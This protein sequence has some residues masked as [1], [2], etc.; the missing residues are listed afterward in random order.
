MPRLV[1]LIYNTFTAT[2][3]LLRWVLYHR[4]LPFHPRPATRTHPYR[5]PSGTVVRYG[6][7]VPFPTA[8]FHAFVYCCGAGFR[9]AAVDYVV[10]LYHERLLRY[11]SRC[12]TVCAVAGLRVPRYHVAIYVTARTVAFVRY[13]RCL[14]TTRYYHYGI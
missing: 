13:I 6:T 9:Y 7:V 8:A 2:I 11:G 5:L 10:L 4:T 3:P 1:R 14:Q 12:V